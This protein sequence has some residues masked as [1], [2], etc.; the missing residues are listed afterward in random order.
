MLNAPVPAITT[1]IPVSQA[2][3]RVTPVCE[4]VL[5]AG[6]VKVKAGAT[7]SLCQEPVIVVALPAASVCVKAYVLVASVVLDVVV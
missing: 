1:L 2:P 3:T 7:V 5:A 4:L 6:D